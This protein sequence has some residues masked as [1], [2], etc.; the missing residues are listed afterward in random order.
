MTKEMSTE[1]QLRVVYLSLELI[2]TQID[3]LQQQFA[4][5]QKQVNQLQKLSG[6][7]PTLDLDS[8][9]TKKLSE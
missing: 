6:E 1:E 9:P 3:L 4:L 8:I 5:L 2:Q 7:F